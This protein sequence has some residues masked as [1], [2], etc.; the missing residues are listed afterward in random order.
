MNLLSKLKHRL[1]GGYYRRFGYPVV[2]C[3]E[4][5]SPQRALLS[6]LSLGM[7]WG[8]RDPRFMWHQNLRQSRTLA[9]LL[10]ERG[11]YVDVVQYD[12]AK[13]IPTASYDLVVSHPGIVSN[14]IRGIPRTGIRLCL[15]TGRHASFIDEALADRYALLRQRRASGLTWPGMGETNEVYNGYDAIACFDGNGGAVATFKDVGVPVY[16]FRNHANP[17]IDFVPKDY[18]MARSGFLYMASHLPVL[19]G[20]D[21]L[22][23]AFADTP[24]R[25]LYICGTVS[26]EIKHLYAHELNKVHIHSVGHVQFGSARFRDLCRHAAWYVSPSASEGCQGTALDWMAAGLVPILSD[27]CGVDTQGAG[28]RIAP[29]TPDSLRA[30]L[31]AAERVSWADVEGLS[32][33]ARDCVESRYAVRHFVEDWNSILDRVGA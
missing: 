8:S 20:L 16:P 14:R 28:I 19:K 5:H 11:Y 25:H 3:G 18:R 1:F 7:R 33:Q 30:V 26:D 29:C 17:D 6:Y 15:R 23:E 27:A 12:D 13:F 4:A 32:C 24:G 9:L 22:I 31:D 21:W 10:A 2:T